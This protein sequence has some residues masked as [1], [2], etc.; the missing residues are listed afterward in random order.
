MKTAKFL[1]G[2]AA[3]AA[4][5][6]TVGAQFLA[7]VAV[8]PAPDPS[9]ALNGVVPPP[10]DAVG[11]APQP[12]PPNGPTVWSRLGIDPLQREYYRRKAARTP[13]GQLRAKL[14]EPLTKLTG[15]LIPPFAPKTP[16]VAELKDPGPVGAA[17][18]AKLDRA[19]AEERIKAVKYLATLDCH[20]WPEAEEALIG[21]LRADRNECVRYEAAVALLN[22]C[23]CTCKVTVALSIAVSCS[24]A[25]GNPSERSA[26]VRAVAAH[27]LDRCLSSACCAPELPPL[28]PLVPPEGDNK[29]NPKGPF[30]GPKPVAEIKATLGDAAYPKQYYAAVAKTPRVKVVAMGRRALEL[31]A[32]F[33]YDFT[34]PIN[35]SDYAAAGLPA[36]VVQAG[37]T[38]EPTT[39]LELFAWNDSGAAI[40]QPPLAPPAVAAALKPSPVRTALATAPKPA[41]EL[42][43][44]PS[45]AR[46]PKV[47]VSPATDTSKPEKPATAVKPEKPATPAAPPLKSPPVTVSAT[48]LS[49]PKLPAAQPPKSP[50]VIPVVVPVAKPL[51]AVVAPAPASAPVPTPPKLGVPPLALPA[52]KPL[53]P[54]VV[55]IPV[56]VAPTVPAPTLAPKPSVPVTVPAVTTPSVAA[57][58]VAPKPSVPVATPV[59]AVPVVVAPTTQAPAPVVAIPPV[60]T[61]PSLPATQAPAPVVPLTRTTTE[62]RFPPEPSPLNGDY[63]P[64][65]R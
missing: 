50:L 52:P 2:A 4:M 1:L 39:L 5:A 44:A 65:S 47:V 55:V 59:V 3:A 15:G 36:A 12:F 64:R 42:A 46:L 43:P 29:L 18:K 62:Y 51:P 28:V 26:R 49:E 58:T 7:P 37:G 8:A 10:P 33:G 32:Q 25:D 13:L 40:A 21:A 54:P 34:T 53:T 16:S 11:I 60:P 30:E 19:G 57:P 24:D 48:D 31:G 17:A 14:R 6:G 27:A 61:L 20:Y 41:L 63:Q 23:C 22:G 38:A 9:A 56:A 45:P 35:D